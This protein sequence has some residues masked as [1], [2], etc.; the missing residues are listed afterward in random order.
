MDEAFAPRYFYAAEMWQLIQD[1]ISRRNP[2]RDIYFEKARKML[3]EYVKKRDDEKMEFEFGLDR[4]RDMLREVRVELESSQEETQKLKCQLAD[5]AER[6]D[7]EYEIDISSLH[8]KTT[9]PE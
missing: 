6:L 4:Y 3:Q 7:E 1:G 5:L 8:L 2:D 9:Q